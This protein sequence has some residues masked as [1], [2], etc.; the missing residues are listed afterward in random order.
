M[1]ADAAVEMVNMPAALADMAE[2]AVGLFDQA[3]LELPPVRFVHHGGDMDPCLGREGLHHSVDGVNVVE[4]CATEASWPTQVMILHE[5]S[6][7]WTDGQLTPQRKAAFQELRGWEHWR[8]YEAAGWH[9]NGTE[10]AAEIMVW[11]LIDRP[12]RIA[13]INQAGCDDLEAGY[14]TLTGQ[15]PLNGFRDL[16]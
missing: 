14:L 6:H 16:C 7:A 8:D 13:R 2:W 4:I 12:I 1:P 5:T 10:Q 3:G 9:N 15:A 11:G